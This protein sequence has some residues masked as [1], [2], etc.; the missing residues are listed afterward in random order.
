MSLRL[1]RA[2]LPEPPV[3]LPARRRWR[4]KFGEAWRGVKLGI[5]GQS[6]FFVHFFTATLVIVAA[7]TFQ[8]E[9]LEWC[10]LVGCIGLVMVAELFNSAVET[11]FRGLDQ[12]SRDKHHG[13]LHIAAG[14]VLVASTIAALVGT[15]VLGHRLWLMFG[16]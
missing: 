14:A 1:L 15:I 12:A 13:A 2:E 10:V 16:L 9:L 4:D 5:R 6:S 7:I 11:L 8:C 3:P